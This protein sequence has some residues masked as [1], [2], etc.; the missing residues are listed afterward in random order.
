MQPKPKL[1]GHKNAYQMQ[2]EHISHMEIVFRF[3]SEKG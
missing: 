3:V 1:G 2:Q